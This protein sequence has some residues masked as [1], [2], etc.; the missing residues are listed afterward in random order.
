M[1]ETDFWLTRL[2]EYTSKKKSQRK[3]IQIFKEVYETF[4][5]DF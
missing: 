1:M 4:I 2:S 5:L 3:H